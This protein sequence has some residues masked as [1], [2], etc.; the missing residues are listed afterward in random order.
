M[1]NADSAPVPDLEGRRLTR[2]EY[3]ALT[4]ERLELLDG[5]LCGGQ[6]DHDDRMS[7]L[8][9]LA[10]NEGLLTLVRLAPPGKWHE[11]LRRTY[12]GKA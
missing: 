11:A 5:F 6:E 4:P 2:E 10:I 7:L 8:K 9:A 3:D 12:G 1:A